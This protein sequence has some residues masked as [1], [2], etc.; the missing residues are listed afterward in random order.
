MY[1]LKHL[2]LQVSQSLVVHL[3]LPLYLLFDVV[4]VALELHIFLVVL[5][6]FSQLVLMLL[7]I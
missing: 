4:C 3:E 6:A 7:H 2:S 1:L 5:F